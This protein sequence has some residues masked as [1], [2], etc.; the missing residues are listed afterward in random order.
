MTHIIDLL[1]RHFFKMPSFWRDRDAAQTAR[2][3]QPLSRVYSRIVTWRATQPAAV[4]ADCPV[5]CVGNFTLGGSGKT[6]SVQL[7][8]DLLKACGKQPAILLRGYGGTATGPLRVDIMQHNAKLVGDEA[9]LHTHIAPTWVAR[10][11]AKGATAILAAGG[12]GCIVMDDG[13]QNPKLHKDLVINVIDGGI[14]FG[15]QHVFPAGP[16]REALTPALE[17]TDAVIIIGDDKTHVASFLKNHPSFGRKP[18]FQAHVTAAESLD[19]L[20]KDTWLAFAGIGRPTKFYD[21]LRNYGFK[22]NGTYDFPD[23]H[24]YTGKDIKRLAQQAETLQSRLLTTTKDWVRIPAGYQHMVEF[25]PVRLHIEQIDD[26][27]SLL[28][29]IWR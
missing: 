15:N 19:S 3:L 23:H 1:R 6:P 8:A 25:L 4:T 28:L 27:T 13:A 11:R 20:L 16:L 22:L 18:I 21:T 26:L 24:P 2:L 17:R 9:L 12:C 14:G 10:D 29:S 7:V 5:I